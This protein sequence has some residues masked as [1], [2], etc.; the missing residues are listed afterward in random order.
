MASKTRL[1]HLGGGQQHKRE[2]GKPKDT[3]R[4]SLPDIGNTKAAALA[5]RRGRERSIAALATLYTGSGGGRNQQLQPPPLVDRAPH[6]L[7]VGPSQPQALGSFPLRARRHSK[8][9]P[10]RT[11]LLPPIPNGMY[12]N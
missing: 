10:S 11:M 2:R 6:H 5:K 7:P 8:V 1:P 4:P 9:T 3:D 12:L